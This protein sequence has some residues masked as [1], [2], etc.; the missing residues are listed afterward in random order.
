MI[1]LSDQVIYDHLSGKSIV[2]LYPT[3]ID[4]TCWFLAIDF[5]KQN[6]KEDVLSF[7]KVCKKSNVPYSIE[8]S[9]SGN[10]AHVW[11]FFHEA[12]SATLARKFGMTLLAKTLE[13]RYEVGMDS[14]DRLFPNQDTLP[15]GG[16]GN[17]IAL[18]L[19]RQA[20]MNSNSV[21]VD[22]SLSP[23][24]DQWVYLS[25]IQKMTKS[26]VQKTIQQHESHMTK[27][28]HLDKPLPKQLTVQ[29]RNGIHLSKEILPSFLLSKIAELASFNNPE[30]YKAQA[31]RMST[32]AAMDRAAFY[33]FKYP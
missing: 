31:K 6:W 22:E 33:I 21:F 3:L 7:V 20:R 32:H 1:E 14:Y 9:R 27:E 15:K 4:E 2:G 17:L 19:Q 25:S 5:D 11:I 18:P 16:F 23:Y 30:F 26:D 29:F 24:P 13:S 8:R 12:L 28:P 10:G